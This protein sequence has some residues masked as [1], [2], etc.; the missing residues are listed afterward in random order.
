MGLPK[1]WTCVVEQRLFHSLN[2]SSLTACHPSSRA[3]IKNAWFSQASWIINISPQCY[4]LEQHHTK[5]Q[6]PVIYCWVVT[7]FKDFHVDAPA[8]II[9]EMPPSHRCRIRFR[10]H[11]G[12]LHH[13][14]NEPFQQARPSSFK[15]WKVPESDFP[16]WQKC[17][18]VCRGLLWS[19]GD[20]SS[21]GAQSLLWFPSKELTGSVCARSSEKMRSTSIAA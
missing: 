14:C 15:M 3:L 7:E 4:Q 11:V 1:L 18:P 5:T 13:G 20:C 9:L 6:A 10:S 16:S 12:S 8:L 17:H 19:A 2:R 21:D